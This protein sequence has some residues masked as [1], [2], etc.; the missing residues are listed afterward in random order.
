MDINQQ[1]QTVE[2][3]KYSAIIKWALII[4]IVIVIN[5]FINYA[6]SMVYESPKYE[7]YCKQEQ[8]ISPVTN[9]DACVAQGGQWDANYYGKPL[10][11][12][13]TLPAGY[14]NLQFTCNNEYEAVRKVYE[15]NIFVALVTLGIIL[16]AGS[17]ALAFNWILSVSSAMAG[18]LSIIIASM[19]YW[20]EADNWLRVIILFIALCALIY[21][22]VR[23]FKN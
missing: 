8:V 3:K 7:N 11:E 23:K 9:Q 22:A 16:V 2:P 10:M 13:E 21:F 17:F 20:G 19:R 12:N 5:L 6:I 4:G 14:C 15:R 18:I 1:N